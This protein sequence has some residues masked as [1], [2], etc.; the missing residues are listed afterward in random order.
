MER[1]HQI[2]N[3]YCV[4]AQKA[5]TT[6]M[7]DILK[8]HPDVFLPSSKEAHFFD[9]ENRFSL[10]FDWYVKEFFHDYEGEKICGSFT[11]EYL[12]FHDVPQRLYH[13]YGD[14][15][16][17]IFIFRNPIERAFSHYLMSKKRMR[18]FESFEIAIG[19]EEKRI[20]NG[21]YND[22]VDYSYISRGF[23]G[24]QLRRYLEFFSPDNML[25]IRFEEDFVRN[26]QK[27]LDSILEFLE[28]SDYDFN[29]NLQSNK[30][31]T[32]VFPAI[33]RVLFKNDWLKRNTRGMGRLKLWLKPI[34]ERLLMREAPKETIPMHVRSKLENLYAKDK[35]TLETLT[36]L[37]LSTWG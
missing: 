23:Y 18:E 34:L 3:F 8:Q 29:L 27:T 6:T 10:G 32:P 9:M 35:K 21:D 15:L 28:L 30:A 2:I 17:L 5:G 33:N 22:K 1:K 7:H 11:P 26:R 20:I 12:Y 13:Q 31:Q 4:G 14:S 25:F 37:D 36:G 24:K 16:K 19:L